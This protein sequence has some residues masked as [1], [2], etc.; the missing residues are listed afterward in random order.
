MKAYTDLSQ[1]KK[2]AKILPVESADMYYNL[3]INLSEKQRHE[4]EW[5]NILK[6][7][8]P[9]K[10]YCCVSCWSLAALLKVMPY[11]SL[12]NDGMGVGK[13]GWMVTVYPNNR[14]LD[15]VWYDNPI[16]ACYEMIIE[17][18]EQKLL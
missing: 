9:I 15:S 11:P 12:S 6:D 18:H 3:D 13:V 10:T 7:V 17:L 1:S 2:L 16:D 14:R 4:P 8:S 5:G